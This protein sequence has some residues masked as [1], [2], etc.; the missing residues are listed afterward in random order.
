VGAEIWID[1]VNCGF[2]GDEMT[3]MH[4]HMQQYYWYKL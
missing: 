2:A 3:I 4:E 1:Q